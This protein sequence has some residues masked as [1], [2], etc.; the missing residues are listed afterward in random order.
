MPHRRLW[1]LTILLASL[2]CGLPFPFAATT[3][4]P[5]SSTAPPTAT[6]TPTPSPSPTPTPLPGDLLTLG[7][8]ALWAGDTS[9]AVLTF[10]AVLAATP[11]DDIAAQ[12]L[13]DLGRALLYDQAYADAVAAFQ[14][15]LA[16]FPASPLAHEAHFHLAEALVG[17]GDPLA[18]AAHYRAY[19]DG[20][21]AIAPYLYEW[22]GDALYAGE[23]YAGAA[24]A[25]QTSIASAPDLSFEVGMR[26]KLA[27]VRVAQGD[28]DS[29]VAEYETILAQA[30]IADYRARV[31]RQL[32]DTLLLAGRYAEAYARYREVVETYPTS[33]AAHPSLVAL[34]EAGVPVDDLTRG[35]V[36]YHAGA[37]D[38]GVAALNRYIAANPDHS[39]AAHFYAGMSYLAV[40]S[41]GLAEAQFRALVEDHHESELWGSGW[42]GLAQSLRDQGDIEGAVATYRA[43]VRAAPGHSRAPEALWNAAQLL[44]QA[45]DLS[46]AASAYEDCWAAYRASDMAAPA[47]LR[48]GLQHYRLGAVGSAINDWQVL[49]ANYPAYRSAAF[50]WLGKAYLAAGQPISATAAFDQAVQA[51]P[52]GYYGLRAAELLADPQAMPFPPADY[53]PPA[54]PDAGRDE[55]E[56]WLANWL[57]LDSAANVGALDAALSADPRLQRGLELWRLG[58]REEGKAELEAL[59]QA[60]TDDALAQYRLALLF[61]DIGLYRS[62]ILAA[63][64]VIRLSPAATVLDAPPFIARLA[65]P[66]Y[67]DDLILANALSEDLPPLLLF[68]LVR[69]ESLFEGFATSSAYAHGL[70]QVIPSTGDYIAGQLGWPPGY[71][72]TDLYRPFVSVRFG[73][74][75][76]ARQRDRFDGRLDVALAAYN[77]GP[78]NA[79]NWLAN[80]GDDPDLF[81][82][83]ITLDET[84]LYLRLIREHYAVYTALYGQ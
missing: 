28:Y 27:L 50:L 46:R 51:D 44:E 32:A 47:L 63:R 6:A 15:L 43:F 41:A 81:T 66:T 1:L 84:R 57:G 69:Q 80:A 30:Q 33:A 35:I 13:L 34:V 55:A 49:A 31:L 78:T 82:E 29:A 11:S 7:Q 19:L 17:A 9:G 52:L 2:A 83:M 18:A 37:Y 5:A 36:D 53:A 23:D 10:Q 79:A 42:M 56:A 75:Y 76:L 70:M 77:G 54:D 16:R 60:T 14:E 24:E 25:Y 40:G 48:G 73:T 64:N 65:Y 67:H 61:R 22:L 4:P 58:R 71:E 3:T 8:E 59:R 72:T 74:W 39:G 45:G 68:S 20:G 12:A 38:P 26:E 21:T 62:S